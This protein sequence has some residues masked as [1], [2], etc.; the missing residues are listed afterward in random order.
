M[1]VC[2]F[3]YNN[4]LELLTTIFSIALNA[5]LHIRMC[6]A[7][8]VLI[9]LKHMRQCMGM[10]WF[11]IN[12]VRLCSYRM[13]VRYHC[14]VI[15]FLFYSRCRRCHCRCLQFLFSFA[16]LFEPRSFWF[17]SHHFLVSITIVIKRNLSWSLIKCIGV[18]GMRASFLLF[19]PDRIA[20]L[21]LSERIRCRMMLTENKKRQ[22]IH[23]STKC[24]SFG[25][26]PKWK[27]FIS[28]DFCF[29]HNVI[30][31]P[32]LFFLSNRSAGFILNSVHSDHIIN[33]TRTA[34]GIFWSFYWKTRIRF[35]IKWNYTRRFEYAS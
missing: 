19:P 34:V 25:C 35:E 1:Q 23:C 27:V 15:L 13:C 6:S 28:R 18:Y 20:K 17:S 5:R 3:P 12:R 21:Q 32:R 14:F 26:N 2:W 16:F 22:H 29:S 24:V 30:V 10:L 11:R 4:M 8:N 7:K 33:S 9:L 31:I